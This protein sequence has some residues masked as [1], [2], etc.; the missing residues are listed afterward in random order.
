MSTIVGFRDCPL[1]LFL[2][3]LPSSFGRVIYATA[4]PL[5]HSTH[6]DLFAQDTWHVSPKLTLVLGLRWDYLGYPTSPLKGGIANFNFANTD[7]IISNYGNTSATAD[8]LN[9][10][11]DF[12]PR[13]GFSYKLQKNTVL[14]M[15]FGR[16]YA[17]S[18]D[19][20]NFGAITN[21]W[22]NATRQDL[23]QNDPWQS[24]PDFPTL[25]SG[26]P[27]FVS[28]FAILAAA[29]N[30]G[31]YPTPNSALFGMRFHNPDQLG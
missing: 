6:T 9:N 10:Y 24:L 20:G 3:G 26:P 17:I 23:K 25:E 11:H 14:R 5:A 13:V 30:P 27:A 28:G 1:R 18:F 22:P 21:D 15:G 7:S 19:G 16:S 4:L 29:G 8:V 31:Q 2:L 12:G